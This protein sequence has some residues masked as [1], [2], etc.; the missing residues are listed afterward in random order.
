MVIAYPSYTQECG[1]SSCHSTL[2]LTL[3][4]N[5]TGTVDASFNKPFILII[6]AGGYTRSDQAFYI[7][8][9]P[10]WADNDQFS[11]TSTSIQ[12]NGIGDLNSNLNEISISVAFTPISI[13]THTIR[14][15]TAGKNDVAQSLDVLVSVTV[16]DA[17]PPVIDSPPDKIVSEGDSSAN[18][19][20][21]PSDENPDHYEIFDNNM[22]WLTG[23][24]DG[25]VIV[26]VLDSLSLGMHNITIVVYDLGN[27]MAID[28]VNVS[29]IDDT[30]PVITP[31]SNREVSEGDSVSL[32]WTAY[33][34]HP[35]YFEI[36][37]NGLLI[38]SGVW[39]GSEISTP[40]DSLVLGL[41]NYTLY[42]RDTSSNSASSQVNVTIVDSTAPTVNS[43]S[44]IQYIQGQ[45]GYTIV[46]TPFD[47]NPNSYEVFRNG[48]RIQQG[49]WNATGE[50]IVISLDGLAASSYNYTLVA[51]D[52]GSNFVVDEV[53]VSVLSAVIPYLNSPQ[54]LFIS[55][56][57]LGTEIVWTALDLNPLGYEV[58]QDGI[59]VKSGP[60]NSSGEVISVLVE[61]L[62]LGDYNFT[63]LVIDTDS[64]NA[65]DTVWV[66]FFDGTPPTIDSPIDIT[67][68]EGETGYEISWAPVDLHPQS[69]IVYRDNAEI[70]SGPWNSS[71]EIITIQV[72]GMSYGEY[73]FTIKVLDI[74]GNLVTDEVNV[75]VLDRTLPVIDSPADIQYE[76]LTTGNSISWTPSDTNPVSYSILRN[77]TLVNSGGWDGSTI[78]ILVD[79]LIPGTYNFTLIVRD[80]G[81][82][83][84]SDTVMVVVTSPIT[85]T[86][87]ST[88]STTSETSPT[89]P[90]DSIF[91]DV[92]IA[93]FALVVG[94][95]VGM[96][97]LVIVV[98]EYLKKRGKW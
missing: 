73:N 69:Y 95:W 21:S 24:W 72:G 55:E 76:H 81:G 38:D 77:G 79:W 40:L 16:D 22:S 29:V 10:A 62:I 94:T 31:L 57:T 92:A 82:N 61:G 98:V 93:P 3:T 96:I 1:G 15:W 4:S 91:D 54:D 6:D 46:W 88:T 5:A 34:L 17:T 68:D 60:W 45:T 67:Y 37:Q 14:I 25:S 58:Y 66:T 11:F 44:D 84:A 39:D 35:D 59:L 86:G 89:I 50:S 42:V 64:N 48:T 85:T 41:Y 33:D 19:T 23:S 26:A 30:A 43:P 71:S 8:I 74:G 78:F 47:T 49:D 51:Y 13:G 32:T 27:N 9:Q 83:V 28:Q 80:I 52:V 18:L 70:Q 53:L 2:S 97:V 75:F 63:I 65:T 90:D 7:A 36:W 12:D 87:T 56:G 20:W